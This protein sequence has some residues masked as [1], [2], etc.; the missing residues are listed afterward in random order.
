LEIV[1]VL[2]EVQLTCYFPELSSSFHYILT[3]FSY[4]AFE[5]SSFNNSFSVVLDKFLIAG[6]DRSFDIKVFD[7][8]G[9][10]LNNLSFHSQI[11][12]TVTS[13]SDQLF[14]GSFDCSIKSWH[15]EKDSFIR[16]FTFFAHEAP[17]IS[18]KIIQSFQVLVS[19][20]AEGRVLIHDTK[21]AECLNS[22]IF[23]AFLMDVN[24][25]G[26]VLLASR[27]KVL[28][29]GINCETVSEFE[30]ENDLESV[31]ISPCANFCIEAYSDE[32][33]LRDIFSLNTERCEKIEGFRF[34][35]V[36]MHRGELGFMY[37]AQGGTDAIVGALRYV[38][39][40]KLENKNE[41]ILDLI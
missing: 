23:P 3:D 1:S 37:W 25:N 14:S 5:L 13:S 21:N 9:K 22:L 31:Q 30:V 16:S 33:V 39:L 26:I 41:I 12:L 4:R 8:K 11:I 27:S 17:V 32:V 28:V 29:V 19:L 36:L 18:L 10:L 2:P 40:K 35:N 6:L 7:M 15:I 24:E 20:S 34:R 38:S